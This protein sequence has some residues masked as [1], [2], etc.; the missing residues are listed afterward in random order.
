MDRR[1]FLN[2]LGV[3]ALSPLLPTQVSTSSSIIKPKRLSEGDTV[4]LVSP[5]APIYETTTLQVMVE[6]L[7]AL[8][9]N[10]K[11][12]E[13]ITERYGYLAGS[14][15]QR[16]EDFN[17][18]VRDPEIKAIVATT[19]GWGCS[20]ILPFIDYEAVRAH[21]KII[22]GYSD[23][24]ALLLAIHA[25]TGLVTFH[26]PNGA[27]EW[28]HFSADYFQSILF[29]G[30]A[31]AM[32]NPVEIEDTLVQIENRIRTINPGTARGRLLGGNLTIISTMMGAGLLPDWDGA[33]LFT[34]DVN[35][36]VY[37]VDR[38][39]TQ[40]KLAGVLDQVSGFVFGKCTD[41][42]PG[43]G[44]GGFTLEDVMNTHIKP[45][46]VPAWSGAM[47]GHLDKKF[48][49]P[50]GVQAEINAGLGLIRMTEPAVT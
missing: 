6:S 1:H 20:R 11:L 5:A 40:L 46:D 8:E 27:S 7:E 18:M 38:M 35:E 37:R 34:E 33:I 2:V 47:I 4:A 30:E 26:G 10:V 16:A 50:I 42:D 43:Q 24:T 36:E 12:G 13:H 45:L 28:N 32:S 15:Q 25:R 41:C 29:G 44:Y 39:L 22:V 23:V 17:R 19:G 14:D 3:G 21:P 31:I 49:V 48:T 9:L